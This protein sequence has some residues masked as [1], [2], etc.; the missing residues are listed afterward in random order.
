MSGLVSSFCLSGRGAVSRM[1]EGGRDEAAGVESGPKT[2][3][4]LAVAASRGENP[5][6]RTKHVWAFCERD[7]WVWDGGIE[8]RAT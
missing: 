6:L 7:F 4:R 5:S 8:A 1:N 3:A 2:S